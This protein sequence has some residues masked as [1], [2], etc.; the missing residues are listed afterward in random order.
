MSS[1]TPLPGSSAPRPRWPDVSVAGSG[2]GALTPRLRLVAFESWFRGSSDL[3]EALP[4]VVHRI[5]RVGV[6]G[7]PRHQEPGG[8]QG[9]RERF[10]DDPVSLSAI[11]IQRPSPRTSLYHL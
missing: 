10:I 7:M 5:L 3:A 9:H 4:E 11:G 2:C 8:H 6:A 1:E